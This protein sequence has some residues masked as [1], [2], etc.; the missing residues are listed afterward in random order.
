[1]GAPVIPKVILAVRAGPVRMRHALMAVFKLLA[2]LHCGEPQGGDHSMHCQVAVP[3]ARQAVKPPWKQV[4]EG[5]ATACMH[6]PECGFCLWM[7][8]GG[9]RW[10]MFV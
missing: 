6:A 8:A 1:M 4:V 5:K 7:H 10:Q 9:S 3:G 2:E